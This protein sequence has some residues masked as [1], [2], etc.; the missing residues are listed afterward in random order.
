MTSSTDHSNDRL[1]KS[2]F[3]LIE[4]GIDT[5]M[6]VSAKHFNYAIDF[7]ISDDSKKLTFRDY[8]SYYSD[9]ETAAFLTFTFAQ[10]NDNTLIQAS[11]R[12][13]YD[14]NQGGFVEDLTW[15][16]LNAQIDGSSIILS[17]QD[18][19]NFTFFAPTLSL[20]I[21]SVLLLTV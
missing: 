3:K 7:H 12:H 4:I 16:P 14:T 2:T 13:V 10:S 15:T 18:G 8:R 11:G 9:P 1:I 17:E 19:S 6:I 5:Y 20:V 21:P